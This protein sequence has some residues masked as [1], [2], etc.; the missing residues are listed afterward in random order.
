MVGFTAEYAGGAINLEES[1]IADAQ[2]FSPATMPQLPPKISIARRLI[3]SYLHRQEPPL[4][5]LRDW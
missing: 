1:E 2:W 4:L 3:D 5:P